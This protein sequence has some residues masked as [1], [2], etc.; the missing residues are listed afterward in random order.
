MIGEWGK[1]KVTTKGDTPKKQKNVHIARQSLR[2]DLLEQL[3][4]C[5]SLQ[6]GHQLINF[7]QNDDGHID[8]VF[9]VDGKLKKAKSDLVVGADGIRSKVRELLISEAVNPLQYTG[10]IVI[11]GICPLESLAGVE[12]SLLDSE[13]VFQTVNGHERIY[14]M[15]YSQDAVMWQLSFP[16]SEKEALKLSKE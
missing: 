1:K 16:I 8:L 5:Q 12:S 11:L 7:S 3:N 10:Y 14:M 4:G 6:W 2:M 9:Q 13:T 15:P